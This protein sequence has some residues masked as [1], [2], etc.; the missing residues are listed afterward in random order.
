MVGNVLV[1]DLGVLSNFIQLYM[2][3]QETC[4]QCAGCEESGEEPGEQRMR[5]PRT[6]SWLF[7]VLGIL[8]LYFFDL[9]FP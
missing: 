8:L 9:R 7:L 1:H 6:R 2:E 3:V 4:R 5:I